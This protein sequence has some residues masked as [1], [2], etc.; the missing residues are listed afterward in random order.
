ML[1]QVCCCMFSQIE[2]LFGENNLVQ[3][4]QVGFPGLYLQEGIQLNSWQLNLSRQC[5][6]CWPF[7][8]KSVLVFMVSQRIFWGCV[9]DYVLWC[10]WHTYR[11]VPVGQCAPL[12]PFPAAVG[13]GMTARLSRSSIKSPLTSCWEQK[14]RSSVT[15]LVITRVHCGVRHLVINLKRN[16][17]KEHT[18]WFCVHHQI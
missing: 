16:R 8:F 15:T 11:T 1:C 5:A 2:S 17:K 4:F 13:C 12:I 3:L 9:A 7:F 14:F 10:P 6:V 18:S